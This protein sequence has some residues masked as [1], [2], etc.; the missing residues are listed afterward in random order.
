MKTRVTLDEDG[1]IT[2]PESFRAELGLA[3][4]GALEIESYGEVIVLRSVPETPSLAKEHGVWVFYG[5]RPL[6]A[7][8]TDEV[9]QQV[10]GSTIWLTSAKE[11]DGVAGVITPRGD[12][13]GAPARK[14]WNRGFGPLPC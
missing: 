14:K 11:N 1:G 5:G 3:P 10:R 12:G 7:S 9:I 13:G 4:G 6:P 2:I 8:V